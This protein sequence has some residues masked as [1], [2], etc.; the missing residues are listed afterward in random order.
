MGNPKKK[1]QRGE[2]M[3]AGKERR[4]NRRGQLYWMHEQHYCLKKSLF[5]YCEIPRQ[6]GGE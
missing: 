1:A 6:L 2:F 4:S 3:L 5:V